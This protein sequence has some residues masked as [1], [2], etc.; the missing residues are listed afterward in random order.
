MPT[1]TNFLRTKASMLMIALLMVF[2]LVGGTLNPAGS[3]F[4]LMPTAAMASQNGGSNGGN[5][6]SGKTVDDLWGTISDDG[7]SVGSTYS[8]PPRRTLV[9]R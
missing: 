9:R 5:G 2:S 8:T 6:G 3:G 1:P 7:T 4:G